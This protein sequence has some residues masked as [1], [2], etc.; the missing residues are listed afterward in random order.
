VTYDAA[1]MVT[2]LFADI[3]GSTFLYAVRGDEE[4]GAGGL[5]QAG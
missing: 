5:S 1:A 4:G 2:V 3:S